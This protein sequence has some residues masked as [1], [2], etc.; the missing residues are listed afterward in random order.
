MSNHNVIFRPGLFVL[1]LSGLLF[2]GLLTCG[3]YLSNK[4]LHSA[5]Y[6]WW[7]S[8]E[9][10]RDPLNRKSLRLVDCKPDDSTCSE[11][12]TVSIWIDPGWPARV[13]II[14]ALPAFVI[15]RIAVHAL[16]KLGVSELTTFMISVPILMFGWYYLVSWLGFRLY[17]Q[18]KNRRSFQ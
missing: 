16:G 4:E 8:F 17:A 2:F 15:G 9:L 3:S 12:E 10:D 5:K 13:L 1:P 11:W 18:L 6:F 7:S 14:S